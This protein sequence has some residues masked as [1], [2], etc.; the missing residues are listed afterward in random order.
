MDTGIQQA[1]ENES[2]APPPNTDITPERIDSSPVEDAQVGA[3]RQ[4]GWYREI[5]FVPIRGEVFLFLKPKDAAQ[6]MRSVTPCLKR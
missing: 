4:F 2:P 5:S 3:L 6:L 1:G